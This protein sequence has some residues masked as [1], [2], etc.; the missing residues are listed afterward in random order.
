MSDDAQQR[1]H[2]A[3]GGYLEDG[4]LVIG[5]VLTIEVA[6][7]DDGRY[8]SHRAGGG[9]DGSEPPT[10]WTALGML[11]GSSTVARDQLRDWTGDP[12]DEDV[13]DE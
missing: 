12:E 5:W 3:I 13:E 2:E 7:Q 8:L 9:I 4:E 6:T 10:V 11:E 1:V